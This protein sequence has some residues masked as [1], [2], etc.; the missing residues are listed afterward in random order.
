MDSSHFEDDL[1]EWQRSIRGNDL[2]EVKLELV[3]Y[4]FEFCYDLCL[5]SQDNISQSLGF[6][7]FLGQF[8]RGRED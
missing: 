1:E 3:S 4:L 2:K 5:S 7:K 6:E 8:C